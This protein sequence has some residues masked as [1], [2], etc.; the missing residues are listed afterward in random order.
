MIQPTITTERNVTI[1]V[2]IQEVEVF[3]FVE[4]TY[5][6]NF[7]EKLM[8]IGNFINTVR[9]RSP[10]FKYMETQVYSF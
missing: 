10:N 1:C 9:G 5:E 3:V 8:V 7:V 4:P 2:E 6:P